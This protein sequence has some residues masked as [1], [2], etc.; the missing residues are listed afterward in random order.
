MRI[1]G[2][3][4]RELVMLLALLGFGGA[5]C[6]IRGS[7][8]TPSESGAQWV[9]L[10]SKHFRLMTDL[11]AEE[12][13]GV[14]RTFEHGY[15]RLGRVLFGG[16]A[17]PD[18]ETQV[19]AFRSEGEFREFRAAPLGGQY[20][21]QLPNDLEL[22]P[23]MLIH[24]GLSPENRI[25]FTHELTHR[26]NHIALPAIPIWLNEGIA[27]YYSTVRGDVGSPV[28]GELDPRYG[29][30]SGSVRADPSHI[31]FQGELL[32]FEKLPRP[33]ELMRFDRR[34]FYGDRPE[35]QPVSFQSKEKSKHNYAAAWALVHMLMSDPALG[36]SLTNALQNR[37]QDGGLA[38]ALGGLEAR[39]ADVDRA[40]DKYIR[41]SI[42]WREHHEG[43]APAAGNVDRRAMS[44]AEVLV[45]WARIDGFRGSNAE[46][47]FERLGR[48]AAVA[49]DDPDVLLWTARRETVLGRPLEAERHLQRALARQPSHAGAQLA[50][51]MLY[52]D[53]KTG[54]VWSADERKKRAAAAFE[55]LGEIATTA[56][57]HN[58]VAI[59]H[60]IKTGVARAVGPAARACELD[61]SCWSCL[62]THAAAM[63][64]SGERASAATLELAALSRLPDDAS[65]RVVQTLSRD[66]KRY[67]ASP[68]PVADRQAS[69]MLFWPD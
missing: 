9:E 50:L 11:D 63:F 32:A 31:V 69:T 40:F 51:G 24:G 37:R 42:P 49:P 14:V 19:I 48:A 39:A 28:V 55:R 8:K 29:F 27:Q 35:G 15:A 5:G 6:V 7:L 22:S 20:L 36:A 38:D 25:L 68:D 10:R 46:R 23:T 67:R 58:A 30:A 66:L 53:D 57:E 64:Q 41:K 60:L 45:L 59:Y 13:Q 56:T 43:P 61:P 1:V 47:A 65:E 62:H 4:C 34:G 54:V 18:F 17:V 52:L 21:S 16:D 3:G 2:S 33:S 26:F 44:E 12:A